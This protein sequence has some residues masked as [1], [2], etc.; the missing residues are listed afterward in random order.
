MYIDVVPNRNSPP[1]ILLRESYRKDG[2]VRKRTL[3]N[4]SHWPP[5]KVERLRQL[6]SGK[7]L[8]PVDAL[9]SIERSWPCGHV[10]AVLGTM[11]RL[12]MDS[13]LASRP[14]RMRNIVMALIAER[15]LHPGSKLAATR[16]W[17][18]STLAE[19]LGV[20]DVSADEVYSALDWLLKRQGRIEKKLARRHLSEGGVAL[21]DL[22]SSSYYG[23]SCSLAR[24]GKNRDGLAGVSCIAY[25]L[26]T[27]GDGDPVSI[28]VYPG[29][30]GDPSTVADQLE[31]LTRRFGLSRVVLVGDR[32]ML[33][34]SQIEVMKKHPGIGW[35]SAL[36]SSQIRSLVESEAI[37]M[38]LFDETNLAEI[39]SP[40]YPGERLIACFNPFLAQD[41]RRT[42]NELLD[43]TERELEKIARMVG[44]RKRKLLKKEEIALKVGR[45]FHRFKVA[46]HFRLHIDDNHLS[47]ERREA[48]IAREA[49]LDGIYVIRTSE[50]ESELSPEDVVRQ[51]KR[52]ALV[53]RAFRCL[54]GI[55][56]KVRPIWLRTEDHVRAHFFLCMLAYSVETAMRR[57]LKPLLFHDEEL[58]ADWFSRDPVAPARPSPSAQYKKAT[59]TTA[60]GLPLQSF[61]TLL[62]H[63]ATLQRHRCRMTNDPT[64]P[65][66][67][68]HTKP[69]PLQE[70][71]FHLLQV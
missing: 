46:K 25:G 57:A 17:K 47:W 63:L 3:A 28:S 8:V 40:E 68:T 32:G 22:S 69:T 33:T 71:A 41:R 39:S 38:S 65:V 55:D 21:Y 27:N 7:V 24:R 31:K 49:A 61:S 45:V 6:L 2:K 35:I 30:T 59:R 4:L 11:R 19:E 56:L 64:S 37:Q 53:E 20:A 51:Y 52:L 34:Q 43:A 66:F 1:A 13:L 62:S 9:F 18:D 15:L 29:N 26:L 42:R 12:K 5:E 50:P 10:R 44:R 67:Y 70:R 16:T 58:E 36:R 23:R 14:S 54:K 48:N 60:D